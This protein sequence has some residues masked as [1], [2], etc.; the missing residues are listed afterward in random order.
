MTKDAKYNPDDKRFSALKS[1][2]DLEKAEKDNLIIDI[3][4]EDDI[5]MFKEKRISSAIRSYFLL[6]FEGTKTDTRQINIE[7]SKRIFRNEIDKNKDGVINE[8]ID[9]YVHNKEKN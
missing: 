6:Q 7:Y 4:G 8:K 1:H 9:G 5:Y 2:K 3:E